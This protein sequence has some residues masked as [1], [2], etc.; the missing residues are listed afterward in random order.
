MCRSVTETREMRA[1]VIARKNCLFIARVCPHIEVRTNVLLSRGKYN[2]FARM[3]EFECFFYLFCLQKARNSGLTFD[4]D[5][6]LYVQ[7]AAL[8]VHGKFR[9]SRSAKVKCVLVYILER[10]IYKRIQREYTYL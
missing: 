10:L 4:P 6:S 2:I 1:R 8:S 7:R 9:G 3:L 5:E